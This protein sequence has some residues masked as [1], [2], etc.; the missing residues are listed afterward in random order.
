MAPEYH[1]NITR[2]LH[3]SFERIRGKA[4]WLCS[5]KYHPIACVTEVLQ[6]LLARTSHNKRESLI[7]ELR[8]MTHLNLFIL[9]NSKLLPIGRGRVKCRWSKV[10][11]SPGRSKLTNTKGITTSTFV[12]PMIRFLETG[13]NLCAS[14]YPANH[15]LQ[16]TRGKQ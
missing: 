15:F 6:D 12:S 10:A 8:D 4:A 11:N 13:V 9:P 2:S 3:A 5:N 1:E 14:R 16:I 7:L